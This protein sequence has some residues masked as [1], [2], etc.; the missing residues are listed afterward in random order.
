MAKNPAFNNVKKSIMK[1]EKDS[2]ALNNMGERYDGNVAVFRDGVNLYNKAMESFLAV[3]DQMRNIVVQDR[4]I[5]RQRRV[6]LL[7][8]LD[9]RVVKAKAERTYR[10]D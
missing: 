9:A 1:L 4:S 10:V 5:P 3:C 8:D 6:T 2:V 7:A